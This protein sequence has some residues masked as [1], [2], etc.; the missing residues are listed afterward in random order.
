MLLSLGGM[1]V[2]KSPAMMPFQ[3]C[4]W[5]E[6]DGTGRAHRTHWLR[7][8]YS[9]RVGAKTLCPEL[10]QLLLGLAVAEC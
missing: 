7:T 1:I 10:G 5:L 2:G 6:E 4:R 3:S 9:Y 8:K